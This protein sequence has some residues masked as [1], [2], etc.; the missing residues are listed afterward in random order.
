[1]IKKV[2]RQMLAAQ[3]LSSMTVM[4]CMLVDS[5]IIGRFL[6]V[7]AMTA[8]GLSN[9]VLLIFAAIGSTLSNGIQVVC[10]K[11]LG[12]G[13]RD[14]T[15]RCFSAS[16][17]LSTGISLAGVFLVLALSTPLCVF[18]GAGP[19]APQNEVFLLTKDYLTGFIIG[20]PAFLCAMVMVPFMQMSG[21]RT[22][23]VASVA[24]MT[25]FDVLFDLINVYVFHGGMLGMGLASSFSYYI[26]IV[27]GG[28]YF[29]T[30]KSMF[31]FRFKAL[32]K[33]LFGDIAK[34][35]VPT[36]LNQIS[37]VL[38][39]FL[40]N[41][42]LLQVGD[43]GN[44]NIA[45]YS[46]IST[47]GNLCYCFSGGVGSVALMMS[48]LFYS[49]ED[50]RSL[51]T[52]VKTMSFYGVVIT[53]SITVIVLLAAPL[54]VGLFLDDESARGLA[55]AGVRLFSLSLIP[56]V[57]NTAFKNFYQG[58]DRISLTNII[59]VLQNF[60]FIALFAVALSPIF[61]TTGI[62]ISW[63]CGESVMLLLIAVYVWIKNKKI[64]VSAPAFAMLPVTLGATE[65]NCMDITVRSTPEA[66]N[67]SEQAFTFC[68]NHG[69][70]ERDSRMISLCIEEMANNIV[71]HGF[72][73]DQKKDHAIDIRLIFKDGKHLIR[74]RDNCVNF[75]PIS[76]M[77]LHKTDDPTVHIGI[78]LVMKTVKDANYVC[79]LGLNNLT[80]V[81]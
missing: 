14:G 29:F 75:D 34:Q 43:D 48:S 62:W 67:A 4:I 1:M 74:I 60:V 64:A 2:F 73:K 54:L 36:L 25:L 49:D 72:H 65:E 11:F 61:G 55:I 21:N 31:R 28:S 53:A 37:L 23:L 39:V 50:R 16:V 71:E 27:I 15:N 46:I 5:I 26:A 18:L 45:A 56:S 17:L 79:S 69:E 80:L 77:N 35:G 22:R 66:I 44:L 38:L 20:A 70:S 13:D 63:L 57:L 51:H 10:G 19:S 30:K 24:A 33:H 78:R 52:I 8:Y 47:I 7:N 12:N 76:Y 59:S 6:G 58:I 32:G 40:F 9:P 42:L 41:K 68:L 81:L 3:I